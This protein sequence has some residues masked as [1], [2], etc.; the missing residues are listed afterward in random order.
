MCRGVSVCADRRRGYDLARDL[1]CA[2]IPCLHYSNRNPDK[3][4]ETLK[5]IFIGATVVN[6][7]QKAGSVILSSLKTFHLRSRLRALT[8][9]FDTAKKNL[10]FMNDDVNNLLGEVYT[11]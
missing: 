8:R 10:K 2:P 4:R 1:M 11:G 9:L 7:K 6:I 3:K 5:D